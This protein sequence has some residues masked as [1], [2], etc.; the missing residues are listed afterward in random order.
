MNY[1]YKSDG[2][3]YVIRARLES[4]SNC[5]TITKDGYSSDYYETGTDPDLDLIP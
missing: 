5:D 3:F 2:D 4:I 1:E